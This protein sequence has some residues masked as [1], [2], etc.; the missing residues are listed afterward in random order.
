VELIQMLPL[1]ELIAWNNK[2]RRC[3]MARIQ[4]IEPAEAGLFAGDAFTQGGELNLKRH[5]LGPV[6]SVASTTTL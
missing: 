3:I 4:G 6:F 2:E 5:D 1:I